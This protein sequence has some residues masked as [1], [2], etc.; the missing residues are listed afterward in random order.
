MDILEA[1]NFGSRHSGAFFSGEGPYSFPSCLPGEISISLRQN[2][3]EEI[4]GK[5]QLGL[6]STAH[7]GWDLLER[8]FSHRLENKKMVGQGR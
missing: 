8:V 7:L 5:M 2:G 3:F 4:S 6:L 1:G